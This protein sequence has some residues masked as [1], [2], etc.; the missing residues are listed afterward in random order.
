MGSL[1]G[2]EPRMC[3]VMV[4]GVPSEVFSVMTSGVSARSPSKRRRA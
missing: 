1:A 3:L 4:Y 2:A